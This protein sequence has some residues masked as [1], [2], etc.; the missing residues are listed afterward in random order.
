MF[1][2]A[3]INS[4][5]MLGSMVL[6]IMALLTIV[7]FYFFIEKKIFLKYFIYIELT[8]LLF[9]LLYLWHM[10]APTPGLVILSS[11]LLYV[12]VG[13]QFLTIVYAMDHFYQIDNPR[14]KHLL[15]GT[16]IVLSA[17][18]LFHPTFLITNEIIYTTYY[19][20]L[21]GPGY[22]FMVFFSLSIGLWLLR[23]YL[24]YRK[25]ARKEL[26]RVQQP[27][28]IGLIFYVLHNTYNGVMAVARP[29]VKP[30]VFLNVMVMSLMVSLYFFNDI[31]YNL[32]L[33]D[34]MHLAY[35]YDDLTMVHSR[36]HIISMLDD[37]LSSPIYDSHFVVMMDLD[38]F[39]S[40]NDIYGHLVGDQVLHDFGGILS[41]LDTK[42]YGAGRL[43]GDEFILLARIDTKTLERD[44]NNVIEEYIT[45]LAG[46]GIVVRGTAIGVSMGAVQLRQKMSRT[47][48]LVAGDRMLYEAKRHG[49][50]SFLLTP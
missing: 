28:S 47:D 37:W 11:R 7:F 30:T 50:N 31:K 33:R 20:T 19:T 46:K 45:R 29:D 15:L 27:I 8:M 16:G 42:T 36:N 34:K 44:M 25:T 24:E 1:Y 40:I 5:A 4:I 48:V 12:S 14:I 22:V 3:N 43:G 17:L 35:M 9:S 23:G 6:T 38:G 2:T 18:L 32:R 39:K 41:R 21:K 49:K 13:I 26:L 10:N